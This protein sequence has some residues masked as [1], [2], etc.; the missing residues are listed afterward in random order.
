MYHE[1]MRFFLLT[2][3]GL[4]D[5]VADEA[6][7]LVAGASVVDLAYRRVVI[8][9]PPEAATALLGL[10]CADD[11]FLLV[12][13]WHGIGRPRATLDRIST[14]AARTDLS[15]ALQLCERLR[16]IAHPP[17]FTVSASFVGRR[18]YSSPEMK[19]AMAAGVEQ[20]HNWTYHDEESPEA[21]SLRLF[22]EHEDALFGV[23]LA[24]VPLH[25]RVYRNTSISGSLKPPVA[26]AMVRLAGAA[27]GCLLL[28]PLCGAGTILIEA[29]LSGAI[30]LGGDHDP[31]ALASA[32][33]NLQAAAV[34][35]DLREWDARRL[36]LADASIDAI[37]SNLPFG[38]QVLAGSALDP[39]Y[40]ELLPE[41]VRVLR[42]AGRLALLTSEP[43]ALPTHPALALI[44][45]RTISLHGQNPTLLLLHRSAG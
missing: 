24:A 40:N 8:E 21:L 44:E 26:A 6:L 3:R 41:M 30:V 16:P 45:Q 20:R 1:A 18:N 15:G 5:L 32:R 14:L 9:A 10:R 35:A 2:T 33:T 11:L 39:L 7:A 19:L 31:Q 43:Q 23:R 17:C 37:A 42:P 22:I 12:D 29:A 36:P 27:P 4:E 34:T 25:R 13:E 28:D 38:R